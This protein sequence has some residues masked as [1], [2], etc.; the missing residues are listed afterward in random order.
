ME[1]WKTGKGGWNY[2]AEDLESHA[3]KCVFSSVD[4]REF[5]GKNQLDDII[6][7]VNLTKEY[8]MS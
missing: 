3:K 7:T 4:H 6:R 2:I 8:N 5:G 1:R